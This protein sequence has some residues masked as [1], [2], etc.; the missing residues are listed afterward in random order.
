MS[1][2]GR[3]RQAGEMNSQGTKAVW[4][5]EQWYFRMSELHI[6]GGFWFRF[7]GLVFLFAWGGGWAG[8]DVSVL[9]F[10][11]DLGGIWDMW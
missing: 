8:F 1:L 11:G 6:F 10:W 4:M 5:W 9:G 7:L 2:A 3:S